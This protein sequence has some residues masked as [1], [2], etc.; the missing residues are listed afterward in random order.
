MLSRERFSEAA[1]ADYRGSSSTLDPD[2]RSG[3]SLRKQKSSLSFITSALKRQRSK[4]RLPGSSGGDS[5][6]GVPPVPPLPS[7]DP[8]T[9]H[10]IGSPPSPPSSL[11]KSRKKKKTTPVVT[12]HV[13]S[14]LL[15]RE[16]E[17][18]LDTNL[19]DMEGVVNMSVAQPDMSSAA[20]FV[21]SSRTSHDSG[22]ESQDF[23]TPQLTTIFSDPF[24]PSAAAQYRRHAA[25]H[26]LDRKV[27]PKTYLPPEHLPMP[28]S[29]TPRGAISNAS[30]SA[31]ARP[32]SPSWTAPES[33]AVEKTGEDADE[34]LYSSDEDAEA[35]K[36][37]SRR[38][39]K[40]FTL[41]QQ[42]TNALQYKIR[43]YRANNTYHIVAIA[44]TVTVREMAK[45]LN[46]RLFLNTEREG[47]RMYIKE[48]GRGEWLIFTLKVRLADRT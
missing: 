12:Q 31:T 33:W 23:P 44:P 17:L 21:G 4:P 8:G 5:P 19:D 20:S 6:P 25:V 14:P 42:Q 11:L 1:T 22:H 7:P 48:R 45:E 38:Q 15:P 41:Q 47:H 10:H 9:F 30:T 3:R 46:T 40:R 13:Y 24:A 18:K 39:T 29:L 27:S 32:P 34:L 35:E 36:R 43:I 16:P 28:V 37:K 2:D 26:S